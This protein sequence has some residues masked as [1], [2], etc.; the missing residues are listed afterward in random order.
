L[1]DEAR[2]RGNPNQID[3]SR[4]RLGGGRAEGF[5]LFPIGKKRRPRTTWKH[6]TGRRMKYG[7]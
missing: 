1:L 4:K 6:E 3:E 5:I 2:I 7:P